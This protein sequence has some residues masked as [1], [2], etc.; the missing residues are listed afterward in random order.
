M[1]GSRS[2]LL[3]DA[4]VLID[5]R[6]SDLTVLTLVAR[7]LRAVRVPRP[8]LAEVRDLDDTDCDRY[9]LGIWEPTTEQL[10][11]AA[12]GRRSLSFHDHLCLLI[13][14]DEG[15]CC[16]TNDKA[17]RRE[18]RAQGVPVRWGLQLLVDLVAANQ[19]G[20]A[21]AFDVATTIRANSPFHVTE[22]ILAKLGRQLRRF[23]D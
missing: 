2:P 11:A 23:Q 20:T 5:F 7:H 18:C 21:A 13:A 14:R 15:W 4:N 19:L 10:T 8:L 9:E 16:A 17:L 6:D 1:P 22:E 3:V 12:A